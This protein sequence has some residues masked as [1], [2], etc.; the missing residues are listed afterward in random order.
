M[1]VEEAVFTLMCC[2]RCHILR[3]ALCLA[4]TGLTVLTLLGQNLAAP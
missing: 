1:R 2:K 4:L 3:V